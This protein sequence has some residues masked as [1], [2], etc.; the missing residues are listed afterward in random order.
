M[1][2]SLK[3]QTEWNRAVVFDERGTVLAK[4]A[5]VSAGDITA[6]TTAFNDRDTT[7]GNG[8]NVNG[9]NYEVHRFY[10]DQGLIYGRT[11]AVDPSHGEGICLARVKRGATG[12]N[13]FALITYQFPILSAKAV[14]DL[15][16]WTKEWIA[17]Q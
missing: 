15:Q 13:N 10:E 1:E 12:A 11:H 4:T 6:M 2:A 3:Q 9:Q 5:D 7:F 14:P 17:N 16:A 8:L